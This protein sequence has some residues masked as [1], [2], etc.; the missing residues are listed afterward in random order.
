MDQANLALW[1]HS[2][3]P[4]T[5]AGDLADFALPNGIVPLCEDRDLLR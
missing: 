1:L 5:A 2:L 3:Q 4:H